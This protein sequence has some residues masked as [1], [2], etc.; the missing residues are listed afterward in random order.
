M[1]I[2][3]IRFRQ[4]GD[5]V[6][7]TVLLNTLRRTFPDATIDFVLD[8]R[9]APLFEH[10]PSISRIIEFTEKEKHSPLKYLRKV[11]R[12]VHQTRYDII[13]DKRSTP[14]TL[15]FTLF[16]LRT[17]WRIGQKKTYTRW[18]CNHRITPCRHDESMVHHML[19][20]LRPLEAV[21]PLQ[22]CHDISLAI[23]PD[24]IDEYHQYLQRQGINFAR[25]VALVV[26]TAKLP[27][28]TWPQEQ[29]TS[30][31]RLVIKRFPNM[32]LIFNYAPGYEELIARDICQELG[33]PPEIFINVQAPTMRKLAALCALSTLYF[34]NEGGAR[35]IAH[36]MGCPNFSICS[37]KASKQTWI[38]Q[39][40]SVHTEA[41]A[42]TDFAPADQLAE[43]SVEQ[44]YDLL[45]IDRVW[46]RLEPFIAER[47]SSLDATTN[48][49][50]PSSITS[51]PSSITSHPSSITSHPSSI[52]HHP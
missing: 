26:V 22:Y 14:N 34:G 39:D 20:T 46:Q 1:N 10:H 50:E 5:A 3:V 44:Q 23:Q 33:N 16:S 17:P 12:I 35:H 19:A 47:L 42:P 8:R 37:P 36:A 40:T 51:H 9:I 45:S 7:T 25:P 15:P 43:M 2:L 41:I 6:M 21:Q 24:E 28:K 27:E 18:I 11:W 48:T 31:L 32:Q 38:P 13:I 30:L 29:M 52:P 49:N 4:M